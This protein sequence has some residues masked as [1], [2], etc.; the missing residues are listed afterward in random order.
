MPKQTVPEKQPSTQKHPKK[1][2][3][4]PAPETKAVEDKKRK[5]RRIVKKIED[6]N[7]FTRI[8]VVKEVKR[9]KQLA[10][11]LTFDVLE[12]AKAV[13]ALQVFKKKQS[14]QSR[15]LLEEED[16]FLYV[17]VT[18]N[19][20]PEEY[21]IRPYQMYPYAHIENSLFRSTAKPTSA[22]T[23]S[24]S[25]MMKSPSKKKFKTWPSPASE[26]SSG[27]PDS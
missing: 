1:T 21:S 27:T 18:L 15:L 4:Q 9:R 16:E 12:L 19:R 11:L 6:F 7:K 25:K 5:E 14:E 3:A 2:P 26:K 8:R 17:E 23:A 13:K 20:L 22:N 10:E 24:S